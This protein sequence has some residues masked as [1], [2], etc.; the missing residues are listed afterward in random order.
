MCVCMCLHVGELY[1]L[2]ESNQSCISDVSCDGSNSLIMSSASPSRLTITLPGDPRSDLARMQM[3][4]AGAKGESELDVYVRDKKMLVQFLDTME[5]EYT[6]IVE[7]IVSEN[8]YLQSQVSETRELRELVAQDVSRIL[9]GAHP[10]WRSLKRFPTVRHEFKTK[11]R[12]QL[13]D[14]R[15]EAI[16]EYYEAQRKQADALHDKEARTLQARIDKQDVVVKQLQ[17]ES[18]AKLRVIVAEMEQLNTKSLEK[19]NKELRDKLAGVEKHVAEIEAARAAEKE[20][21]NT[22]IGHIEAEG[23][24]K[25][26]QAQLEINKLNTKIARLTEQLQLQQ[27]SPP[28]HSSP[29]SVTVAASPTQGARSEKPGYA[30]PINHQY[31][32]QQLQQRLQHQS[33]DFHDLEQRYAQQQH[34]LSQAEQ[35]CVVLQQ[36]VQS[37]QRN[38]QELLAERAATAA[39]QTN[40]AD[41]SLVTAVG[42]ADDTTT[43]ALVF[44]LRSRLAALTAMSLEDHR[45][46]LREQHRLR[47]DPRS[48]ATAV[49]GSAYPSPPTRANVR[50]Q[51]QQFVPQQ[52]PMYLSRPQP[53]Q[54]PALS[55][56]PVYISTRT[57]T[58]V[59]AAPLQQAATA[60]SPSAPSYASRSPQTIRAPSQDQSSP[61][62]NYITSPAPLSPSQQ[63]PISRPAQQQLEAVS[64]PQQQAPQDLQQLSRTV[65]PVVSTQPGYFSNPVHAAPPPPPSQLQPPAAQPQAAPVQYQPMAAL[66]LPSTTS[67]TTTASSTRSVTPSPPQ[68]APPSKQPELSIRVIDGRVVVKQGDR[69]ESIVDFVNEK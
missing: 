30:T 4:L 34:Q 1:R 2:S 14:E 61:G 67:T 7:N 17:S 54:Q 49:R 27:T 13:T 60:V 57:A 44:E 32:L 15:L 24:K 42:A 25:L 66:P 45:G 26:K 63:Q 5:K 38:I 12:V 11:G 19:E 64:P 18:D 48:T 58:Q 68:P 62:A 20:A 21:T 59:S 56:P 9:I 35:Q 55:Q 33:D 41:T 10:L 46:H 22:F 16:V 43:P 31:Q 50:Q 37:L 51:Q 8:Q 29:G 6:D 28:K 36:T 39:E 40:S 69:V 52:P 65:Q 23:Q 53:L 3:H 47:I